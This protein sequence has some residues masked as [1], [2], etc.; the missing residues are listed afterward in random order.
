MATIDLNCD[1]GESFGAFTIGADADMMS[2]ITSAS[3]ACGFHAGDP[4][5]MRQTVRLA[6]DAGVAVGAHPG[7]PDLAGFGRREMRVSPQEVEDMVLYQVGALGAIAASEGVRLQHVKAHGA[8]YNMAARDRGLAEALTR[9][10]RACDPALVLFGLAG[11][12]MLRA[13][14]AAGLAVAAEGFADRAYEPDGSLMSRSRPDAIVHDV[15]SVVRRG[16]R[17]AAEGKVVTTDGTEIALRVDT[18]CIHGDTPGALELVR[19]VRSGLERAGV[20]VARVS[21]PPG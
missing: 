4:A 5:V 19:A 11:S 17:M 6:R 12:E 18:I 8:L 1:V 3:V 9:A 21:G 13:G 14:A 10:V 16:V 20:I 7:L 15:G 2:S